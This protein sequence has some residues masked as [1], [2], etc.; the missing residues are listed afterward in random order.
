MQVGENVQI[1]HMTVTKNG[2]AYKL[3]EIHQHL[4]LI[5]ALL[6]PF[7]ERYLYAV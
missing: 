5:T 6:Y 7:I 4:I 2:G 1:D 3:C